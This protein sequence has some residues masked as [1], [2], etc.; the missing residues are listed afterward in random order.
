MKLENKDALRIISEFFSTDTDSA[1]LALGLAMDVVEEHMDSDNDTVR[2]ESM[3]TMSDIHRF[4]QLI[5]RLLSQLKSNVK[6]R[7]PDHRQAV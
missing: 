6:S 7:N 3:L 2:V 4:S 1:M 5:D